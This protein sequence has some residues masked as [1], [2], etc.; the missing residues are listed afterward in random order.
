MNPRD[1]A[2]AMKKMGMKQEEIESIA[3]IIRKPSKDIILRK[4]SV[5]K[6]DMMGQVQYQVSGEEEVRE[7]EPEPIEISEEDIKTVQEQ[8]QVTYEKAKESIE[9]YQGNLAEA[10]INLNNK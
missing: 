7:I 8:A 3:V 5:Q 10:I 2:K 4:P 9:K 6:I 1:V